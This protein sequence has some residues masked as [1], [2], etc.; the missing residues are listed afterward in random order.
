M[1]EDR[2]PKRRL[3]KQRLKEA[4]RMMRLGT[5]GAAPA[6]LWLWPVPGF[7]GARIENVT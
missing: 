4:G 3:P 5:L 1:P 7:A 2:L 6:V